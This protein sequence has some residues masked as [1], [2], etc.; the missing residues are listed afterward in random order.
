[1]PA[2]LEWRLR[3]LIWRREIGKAF[4]GRHHIGL[5]KVQTDDMDRRIMPVERMRMAAPAAAKIKH[6]VA[7][8]QIKPFEINGQHAAI[9]FS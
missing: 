3:R 6:A 1:M 5:G 8:A 2:R 7:I 4:L 9:A